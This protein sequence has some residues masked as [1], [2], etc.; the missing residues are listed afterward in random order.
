MY[1]CV[2]VSLGVSVCQYVSLDVCVCVIYTHI[3]GPLA[4]IF[5][6]HKQ[7]YPPSPDV[8]RAPWALSKH[9]DF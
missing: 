1:L 4:D 7:T 6:I 8:E 2:W 3:H 9:E 5:A